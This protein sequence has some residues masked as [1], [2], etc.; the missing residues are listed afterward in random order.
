[1]HDNLCTCGGN[2]LFS[3]QTKWVH[4]TEKMSDECDCWITG[5]PIALLMP[6]FQLHQADITYCEV[7][8]IEGLST[9]CDVTMQMGDV[10]GMLAQK[11]HLENH[12]LFQPTCHLLV[13]HLQIH[14]L[15]PMSHKMNDV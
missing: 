6:T 3:L 8:P 11:I 13:V 2:L 14:L 4:H 5:C 1:M 7:G 9:G 12:V 15:H 10:Q